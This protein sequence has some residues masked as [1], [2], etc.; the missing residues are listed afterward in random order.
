[1]IDSLI[2]DRTPWCAGWEDRAMLESNPSAQVGAKARRVAHGLYGYPWPLF[3]L[4][5][6]FGFNA[7]NSFHLPTIDPTGGT[8]VTIFGGKRQKTDE[9]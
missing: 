8:Y 9:E 3:L 7:L 5:I 6:C 4:I 2:A 1:M